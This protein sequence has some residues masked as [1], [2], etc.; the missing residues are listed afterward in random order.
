[1]LERLREYKIE[2]GKTIKIHTC[3][4]PWILTIVSLNI[5]LRELTINDYIA[6]Y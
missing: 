6:W 3:N 1:M 2:R 5:L 4:N